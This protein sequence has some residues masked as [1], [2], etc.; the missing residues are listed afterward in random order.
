MGMDTGFSPL[1]GVEVLFVSAIAVA[2]GGRSIVAAV[3]CSMFI[4]VI[5]NVAAVCVPTH[6]SRT[7]VFL[8]FIIIMIPRVRNSSSMETSVQY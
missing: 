4:Y 8:L 5:V 3:T 6:W 2:L 1:M 7:V